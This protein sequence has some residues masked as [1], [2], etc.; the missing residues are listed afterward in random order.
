MQ[1][2]PIS[3][4]LATHRQLSVGLVLLWAWVSLSLIV[5]L[6][7]VHRTERIARKL[8]WTFLLLVP[9]FGWLCYG[10]LFRTP[11]RSGA[12]SFGENWWGDP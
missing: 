7:V 6:W 10:G 4:F 11:E 3:D 5:R 12:E 9:L 1:N 2:D 8:F